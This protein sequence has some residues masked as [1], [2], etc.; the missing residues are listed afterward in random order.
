M[1]YLRMLTNA[2]LGG[3]FGAAF[4]AVIF[5]QLNPE[6]PLVPSVVVP[7]Y[8]VI[9]LFYGAHIAVAFYVLLVARELFA[10]EAL[11]PGWLSLRLLAWE[12]AFV[13]AGAT[14]LMWI[15]L[16]GFRLEMDTETVR[17]LTA[18]TA[19]TAVCTVLLFIIAVVHY[20]VGR[21][22]TRAGAMLLVLAGA[23][24]LALPVAARGLGRAPVEEPRRTAVPRIE[25]DTSGAR[26]V[27]VLFDGASLEYIAPATA[28][29]RLPNFG[30]LLDQGASMHLTT[31]RPTQPAAVW[32]AAFTGK[33]PQRNGIRSAAT[34]AFGSDPHRITLLPDMLFSYALVYFGVL[35][36]H[37]HTSKD[38]R[39][40][41]LWQVLA[42]AGITVGVV[43]LPLT[44]PVEPLPG[45]MVSDRA[46]S[47]GSVR[48]ALEGQDL[49]YPPRLFERVPLPPDRPVPGSDGPELGGVPPDPLLSGRP[50]PTA[51]DAWFAALAERLEA[52]YAP[53]VTLLRLTGI[54]LAG[55]YYLR[56][57]MPREFGD[58]SEVDQRRFGE[59]LDQ[60][61]V[62]AD[63]EIGRV[64]ASLAP[65]DVLLVVSG[66]GMQP[67]TLSKRL[68][69]RVL[70]QPALTDSHDRAPEGF[71]L[72]YGS[73]VASGKFPLGSVTDVAP[74]VL[75]LLGLPVGRDMDGYARTDILRP[76]YSAGRPITF[77]ASYD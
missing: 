10:R 35:D 76:E 38:L 41:I 64:L 13:A 20:S 77:I 29:G 71:L 50:G 7:L 23:A 60:Q 74:T 32:A 53:R 3:A 16:E 54:D 58:V 19:A 43:G 2:A 5:L 59:V 15:N 6:L 46:T 65:G 18:G 12:S 1:R 34:Y 11:S 36:E 52:E 70:Q 47:A 17:G 37:P 61:Y 27:V 22:A 51:R 24:S 26:V 8:A 33:A 21:R 25:A 66:F 55:H 31:L 67:V 73:Q 14:L 72:A 45:F 62:A 69:A 44:D 56:Y 75:Y 63:A 48:L 40:S 4:V 39:A 57:A 28:Q 68:L 9:F 42:R 49:A 30:R